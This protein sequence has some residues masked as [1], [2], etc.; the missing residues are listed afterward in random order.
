MIEI[1]KLEDPTRLTIYIRPADR[2]VLTQ[3]AAE[4]D[5]SL[6]YIAAQAIRFYY[7]VGFADDFRTKA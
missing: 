3:M 6:S 1:S 7:E 5:R 2:E 4:S